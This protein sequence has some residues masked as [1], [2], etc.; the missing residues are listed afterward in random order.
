MLCNEDGINISTST[1]YRYLQSLRLL[2]QKAQSTLLE[3]AL[4]LQLLNQS[5]MIHE[6]KLM[7]LKCIQAEQRSGQYV[8]LFQFFHNCLCWCA[9]YKEVDCKGVEANSAESKDITLCVKPHIC[10]LIRH[11]CLILHNI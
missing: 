4:C 8:K 9:V 5:K 6:Y 10:A 11:I 2:R 1:L 3:V 7:C